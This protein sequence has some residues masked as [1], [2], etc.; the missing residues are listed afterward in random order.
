MTDLGTQFFLSESDVGR[1]RALVSAERLA[2][3][4][5]YVAPA[6]RGGNSLLCVGQRMPSAAYLLPRVTAA[7]VC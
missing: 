2:D 5:P 3:L 1:N 4:N 7:D 6:V